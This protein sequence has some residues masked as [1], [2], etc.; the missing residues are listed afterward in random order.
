MLPYEMA[1]PLSVYPCDVDRV[2]FFHVPDH[3]R[4]RILRWDRD[5]HVHVIR[6]QVP[7]LDRALALPGQFSKYSREVLPELPVQCLAPHRRDDDDVYLHSR[8]V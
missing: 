2:L 4:Y 7:F 6:H 1:T 8:F 3:L 5:H